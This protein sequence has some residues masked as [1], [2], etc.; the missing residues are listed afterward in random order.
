[1][2]LIKCRNTKYITIPIDVVKDWENAFGKSDI[3]ETLPIIQEA[4]QAIDSLLSANTL[5]QSD[6]P[7]QFSFRIRNQNFFRT[8]LGRFVQAAILVGYVIDTEKFF[9]NS[10]AYW[11]KERA[12]PVEVKQARFDGKDSRNNRLVYMKVAGPGFSLSVA[13]RTT[14]LLDLLY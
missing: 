3:V 5:K 9:E 14:E 13:K 8:D 2:V 7:R 1:M 11:D 10:G 4:V 12:F 6:I